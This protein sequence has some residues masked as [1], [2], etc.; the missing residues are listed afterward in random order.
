M[1]RHGDGVLSNEYC[2][3]DVK[4][5]HCQG[6]KTF[7]IHMYHPLLRKIV[8]LVTME[9]EDETTQTF[10]TFWNEVIQIFSGDSNKVY[11]SFA[12]VPQIQKMY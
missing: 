1:D 4:H 8:T 6:F 10:K 3:L 12:R 11:N 7:S 5:N 9:C 2:Y